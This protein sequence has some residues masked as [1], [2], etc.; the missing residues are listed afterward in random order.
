MAAATAADTPEPKVTRQVEYY[1]VGG[2]TER[3]ILA[4]MT[5]LGPKT[6][7]GTSFSGNSLWQADWDF[8]YAPSPDRSE[9]RLRTL[10][11]RVELKQRLPRWRNRATAS[12]GLGAKWDRYV[13]ALAVHE[14]GH[15]D[16]GRAVG[17]EVRRRLSALTRAPTCQKL[18]AAL[19]REGQA[20]TEEFA[21]KD[22]AYDTLT[23]HGGT[24]GAR[25]P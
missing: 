8:T 15:D 25:F 10:S 24:Q 18:H 5:R 3:E 11:V 22:A 14:N 7:D 19:E 12:P 16:I 2:T 21:T 23:D 1:E 20:V 4:E 13:A 6:A 17:A 9:C